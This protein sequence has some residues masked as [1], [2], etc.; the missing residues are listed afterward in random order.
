MTQLAPKVNKSEPYKHYF[1]AFSNQF[2]RLDAETG[3]NRVRAVREEIRS[4]ISEY[5]RLDQAGVALDIDSGGRH[6]YSWNN[7]LNQRNV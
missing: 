7:F 3:T 4:A 2:Q 5:E 6:L 1:E